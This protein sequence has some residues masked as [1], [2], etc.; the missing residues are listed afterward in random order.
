VAELWAQWNDVTTL[1]KY[2]VVGKQNT[3]SFCQGAEV[4]AI[5]RIVDFKS[6]TEDNSRRAWDSG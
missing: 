5:Q 3:G 1:R 2:E 6:S 4:R